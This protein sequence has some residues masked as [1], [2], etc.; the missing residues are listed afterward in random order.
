[1][2]VND[3]SGLPQALP[4]NRSGIWRLWLG[5]LM[6]ASDAIVVAGLVYAVSFA[7]HLGTIGEPGVDRSTREL[8]AV[9]SP[10]RTG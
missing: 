3:I 1:M 10:K 2:S 6:A 8:A 9:S 4:D 5:P 7:Y